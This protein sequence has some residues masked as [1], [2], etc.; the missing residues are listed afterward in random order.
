MAERVPGQARSPFLP[1]SVPARWRRPAGLPTTSRTMV[2]QPTTTKPAWPL[3]RANSN[4][5]GM[6]SAYNGLGLVLVDQGDYEQAAW[7]LRAEPGTEPD[8]GRIHG[9]LPAPST[10]WGCVRIAKGS[11]SEQPRGWRKAWPAIGSLGI[12]KG[13]PIRSIPGAWS[14]WM[15]MTSTR[16]DTHLLEESWRCTANFNGAHGMAIALSQSGHAGAAGG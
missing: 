15:R 14:P 13:W 16:G 2:R 6:A 5:Q 7:L 9:P 4:Q 1:R 12:R 11:S 8:A 3:C 10:T